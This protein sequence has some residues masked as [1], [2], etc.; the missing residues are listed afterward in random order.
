MVTHTFIFIYTHTQTHIH[1][2]TYIY[3]ILI[4]KCLHKDILVTYTYFINLRYFVNN[5]KVSFYTFSHTYIYGKIFTY[6]FHIYLYTYT[7]NNKIRH[8]DSLSKCS[9]L[10]MIII[11]IQIFK[12]FTK[13]IRYQR[14]MDF[15]RVGL[16]EF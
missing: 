1:S 12:V 2:H 10:F 7:N 11:F 5:F 4:L 16:K 9:F 8:L 15:V 3:I 13:V 6:L 14:R